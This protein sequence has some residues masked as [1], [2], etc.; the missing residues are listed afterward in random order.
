MKKFKYF[1]IAVAVLAVIVSPVMAGT[2]EKNPYGTAT[3]YLYNMDN[4]SMDSYYMDFP[5]LTA[6][7][8]M[9]GA[10]ATQT[11]TNKTLTN[12][13]LT[14]PALGTPASGVM[15]NV[16]GTA[17]GLTAGTVTT[18]ANLTGEV[19]SVGNAAT[20]ATSAVTSAKMA[21]GAKTHSVVI[22]VADPGAAGADF[23]AG[24]VLWRPSVAVT[25]TK[26]YLVPGLVY[27]AAASVNDAS[28]VVTNAAV[29]AVAT[30]AIVTALAAGSLN[31]MGTITNASVVANTDVTIA[32]TANGTADAPVQNILIE[33]T[34]VN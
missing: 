5:T 26:V 21:V 8:T 10:A 24:Y 14:A 18:N 20:I 9:V 12:P 19:T 25:I 15:T 3:P 7:D 28:V 29:G 17:A 31:D 6:N 4:W 2:V 23:A 22:Q 30:L 13:I 32:V 1:L 16:T 11:L 33:Y 34:T 27:I